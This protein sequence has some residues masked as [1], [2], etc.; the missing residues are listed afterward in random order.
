MTAAVYYVGGPDPDNRDELRHS[1]RSVAANAPQITEA[2]VIGDVPDWFAGVKVPLEPRPEKFANARQSIT[3]FV[4][5]PGAPES[6]VLTMDD[7]FVTEPVDHLPLIHLGPVTNYS[8][9]KDQAQQ[10]TYA[11]A[12]RDTANYLM[13]HGHREPL[14]YLAHTP[15]HLDTKRVREFLADY[16]EHLMLEPFL[17]YVA[18][19][20]D[21]PGRRGGNAKCKGD[22]NFEHKR[23]LDIPYLSSNPDSWAGKLGTHI[24]GMFT[25]PCRWEQ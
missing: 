4:N 17:L 15:I 19:G 18:A 24:R 3:T 13:Q 10:G 1:L 6:F 22:D 2:W 7:V 16:P 14:A 8:T 9:F 25:T 21:G 20:L 5:L 23:D 12:V 11:R